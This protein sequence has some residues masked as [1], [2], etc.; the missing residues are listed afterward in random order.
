MKLDPE[1]LGLLEQAVVLTPVALG[2]LEA[3]EMRIGG[4]SA[5]DV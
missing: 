5:I 4:T 2:Y 1:V 3:M